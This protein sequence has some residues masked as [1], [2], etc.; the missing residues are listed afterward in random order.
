MADVLVC[1][2][3]EQQNIVRKQFARE[4]VLLKNG[5]P[6][7][8]LERVPPRRAEIIWVSNLKPVKRPDLFV[9]L[10]N[11][12]REEDAA[13]S[14]IGA[15]GGVM[16]R[17]VARTVCSSNLR[18]YGEQPLA[19][20]NERLWGCRGLVNTS[21]IEGFPNTFIQAWARLVPVVSL[22][23][24]PD[25][26]IEAQH[27]GFHSGDFSR[28]VTHTRALIRN[29][30]LAIEMGQNGRSYV[31]REHDL[32]ENAHRFDQLLRQLVT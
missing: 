18:F 26:V 20:V 12:L 3:A 6:L 27:L 14:M 7:P 5:H 32:T 10:A 28:L 8:S 19:T 22:A 15:P 30:D 29:R 9:Q 31:E 1:Q 25:G 24:D 16:T 11:E 4:T 17:E 2:T 13:F 23:I 21:S